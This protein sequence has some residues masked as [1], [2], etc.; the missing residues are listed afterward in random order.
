MNETWVLNVREPD[1]VLDV[2]ARWL[3][4]GTLVAAYKVHPAE[5]EF[6]RPDK[7]GPGAAER[8]TR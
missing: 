2:L 6:L 4:D 7:K 8:W 1:R 3:S 5:R